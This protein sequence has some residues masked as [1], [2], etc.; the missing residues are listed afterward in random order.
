MVDGRVF[1]GIARFGLV[2]VR[3]R[4]CVRQIGFV[5]MVGVDRCIVTGLLGYH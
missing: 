2:L 4:R 3:G 5:S 1:G